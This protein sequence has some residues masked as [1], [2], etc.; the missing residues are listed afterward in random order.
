MTIYHYI[1]PRY[2]GKYSW[3]IPWPFTITLI[4]STLAKIPD[5]HLDHLP[6]HWS[7]IHWKRLLT[8][9]LTIYH[10]IDPRYTGKY[11][12]WIPWPFT[13][14]LIHSTLA[15]I[16]DGHLDHLPLHWSMI[17]W[18]RFLTDSLTI[19]HYIDPRYTDKDCWRI[20]WPFT[21]TLIHD[22]LAN[23]PDGYLYHLPLHWSTIHW[24]RFLTESLTIYHYIDPRYTGK[25]FM[26]NT[27]T[28]CHYIDPRYT[29]KDSW[30]IPWSFT[31]TLIHG[32][33]AMITDGY[34]DHLPLHWSMV[35]W[36]RFLTDTLTIY[37]YIDPRYTGKASWR[38]HWPFT[39]T[40]IHDT[41]EKIPGGYRDHLPLHWY[42]VQWQ[43]FLT[44]TLIIYHY[45]DPGYT[46]KCSWRIPWPFTITLIHDTLANIPDGYLDHLPLHWSAIHWQRFLADTLTIY[47]YIDPRYTGK[48]SW[49]IHWQRIIL[50][51]LDNLLRYL[52]NLLPM[53]HHIYPRCT[54]WT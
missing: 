10:Y 15:K 19:Y 44:N 47:H 48:C 21:V 31:I 11:S 22:A 51:I 1:D 13:I 17:H 18:Q 37:H 45:I 42:T 23:I 2:T 46:G 32:T 29:G 24:R 36:Q 12:W 54:F 16:P 53:C 27:L 6:L 9:T 3:W 38:I 39:M 14:T 7:T 40:L 26:T 52:T 5:G 50:L 25:D 43:R 20:P 33:L 28:I 49:R 8:D 35:H 30:W 41:L 34:L 4:H